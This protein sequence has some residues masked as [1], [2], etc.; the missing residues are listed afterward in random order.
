MDS[1]RNTYQRDIIRMVMKDNF[2]HPT[3]DE[4]YDEVKKIDHR[5]SRGTVYRNLSILA[6]DGEISHYNAPFGPDHYDSI[7][8]PHYHFLC[9]KCGK[10]VDAKI[11]YDN[12]LNSIANVC[13]G[14]KLES[15]DLVFVGICKDCVDLNN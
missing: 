8:E 12:K 14:F 9:R 4:I 7:L 13:D 15:H 1:R 5:I 6:E 10:L 2:N 11:P 3:A